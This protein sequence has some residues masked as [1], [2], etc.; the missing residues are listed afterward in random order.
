MLIL[1]V[2]VNILLVVCVEAKI[3]QKFVLQMEA[4]TRDFSL[5]GVFLLCHQLSI[6]DFNLTDVIFTFS[7]LL[8]VQNFSHIVRFP[9]QQVK[10]N[11]P[12][13]V[14]PIFRLFK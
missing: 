11:T 3:K 1:K 5:W 9:E 10:N 14:F 13:K 4:K 8:P 7:Q 12:E 6:I 2:D